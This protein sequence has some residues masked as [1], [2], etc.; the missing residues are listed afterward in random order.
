MKSFIDISVC[1]K[2]K[3]NEELCGDNVEYFRTDDGVIVVLSDGLGSGVKANIL[4]TLT[5]KIAITMLKKGASIEDVVDTIAQT[6]PVCSV[7]KLAYS[8]FTIIKINDD[9]EVYLVD[10][11]NPEVFFLREGKIMDIDYTIQII[12]ER[13]IKESRFTL[14]ENDTMVLV[15]DG[16]IHAGA[17][18]SLNLGW[19]WINVATFLENL[20]TGATSSQDTTNVLVTVCDELYMHKPGDDMTVVT[21]KMRKP[22]EV[23]LFS[24][25][26]TSKN[27]DLPVVMQLINTTG[28]KI[29]CGGTAANI[30]SR[31]LNLE[32]QTSFDMY[33]RSIPPIAKIKGIDLVTEG[34]LTLQKTVDILTKIKSANNFSFMGKEDGASLLSTLLYENCTHLN[35]LIGKAINP[36]HQNPNFPSELSIKLNLILS[37]KKAMESLDKIVSLEYY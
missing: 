11:D 22:Q 27:N 1:S 3:N 28:K 21:L 17:G 35:L 9:G 4:S 29:V 6:L 33:D 23:V 5:T 25:P 16:V 31:E 18:K 7:R 20:V 13:K 34:I 8:T 2:N 26:P 10:F 36:A 30:V 12:N 37:L 24:G 32:I 15:S 14:I 19:Q